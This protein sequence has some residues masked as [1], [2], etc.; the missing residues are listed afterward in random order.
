MDFAMNFFFCVCVYKKRL[1]RATD[2]LPFCKQSLSNIQNIVYGN[3][4]TIQKL[5]VL[6]K[7]VLFSAHN[8]ISDS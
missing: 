4:L 3:E 2:I 6:V 5:Q 1:T 8:A 7:K